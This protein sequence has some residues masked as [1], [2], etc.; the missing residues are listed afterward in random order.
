[1][2]STDEEVVARVFQILKQGSGVL[3]HQ[4]RM[5][6]VIVDSELIPNSGLLADTVK[7]NPGAGRIGNIVVIIV[8]GSPSGHRALLNAIN[9]AAVS[10]LPEQRNEVFGKIKQVLIHA[11]S[12]VASYKSAY[13]V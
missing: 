12:L 2:K 7:G 1:M 5:R 6:W 8:P 13:G 3:P 10:S 11:E 9:E 4:N